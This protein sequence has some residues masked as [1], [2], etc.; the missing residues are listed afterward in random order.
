MRRL[1]TG[2]ILILV[3][4]YLMLWAPA[5]ML[6]VAGAVFAQAALWEFFRMAEAVSGA[7]M[8]HVPA[9]AISFG[10]MAV[11]LT[12]RYVEGTIAL[13]VLLTL[14]AL[15]A[16]MSERYD[17]KHYFPISCYTIAGVI[18]TTIPLGMIVWIKT[19]PGGGPIALFTMAAV[20]ASDSTAYFVGK[21]WGR[22]LSFPRI[23]PKKTW[24]G[25]AGSVAGALLVGAAGYYIFHDWT[26][27]PFAAAVNAAA[28]FGDLAESAL[29][30]SAGV[31]DSSQLV[32]GHG[33]VLDR[34]DA[35]LF[36]AP[37]LWYYWLLTGR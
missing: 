21:A 8:L 27:I 18:Y 4:I 34:I 2:I 14:M 10:L 7:R 31:K 26:L 20:W 9:H 12:Q 30:R 23:S 19:Q 6:A 28:Q 16:A 22:H 33:G 36:A 1:V 37:L 5:W 13:L 25:V 11:A 24:E 32:P 17:L 29:K 35:L 15:T 3:F